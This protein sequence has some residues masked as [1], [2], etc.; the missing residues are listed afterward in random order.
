MDFHSSI[1]AGTARLKQQLSILALLLGAMWVLELVDILLLDQALNGLGVW[2]RRV[3][4]LWGI[5]LMP[6]LHGGLGH[7]T[8]NTLPFLVLG[9]LVLWRR[10]V[11]FFVVT[12]V[13]TLLTGSALW[14]VGSARAVYIGASGVVFGY[15]GF[16]VFRGYFERSP[17]SL[18]VALMVIVLYGGLLVGVVP[19]GNGI[20]WEAHL[21]G[22]LSGALCARVLSHAPLAEEPPLVIVS[23]DEDN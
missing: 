1:T 5:V 7:L 22:F 6:L 10:T 14:L 15:F 4:G 9:G 8:A 17:Q 3:E 12:L 19:Q 23:S 20:S 16:L 13:T 21:F 18:L 2:P 11:D